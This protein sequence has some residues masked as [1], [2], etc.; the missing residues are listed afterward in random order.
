VL[1][2]EGENMLAVV[3]IQRLHQFFFHGRFPF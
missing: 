1:P 2:K 3:I